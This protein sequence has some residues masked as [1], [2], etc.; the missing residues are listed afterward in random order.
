MFPYYEIND[1]KKF[2]CFGLDKFTTKKDNYWRFVGADFPLSVA[3]NP[4]VIPT[5]LGLHWLKSA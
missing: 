4:L 3:K 2:V 5:N 1:E